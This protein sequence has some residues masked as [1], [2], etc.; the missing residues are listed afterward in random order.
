MKHHP[1]TLT[2]L[3]DD[4]VATIT[5]RGLT[6]PPRLPGLPGCWSAIGVSLLAFLVQ[7]PAHGA[8][9]E[10]WVRRHA[11]PANSKYWYSAQ[12]VVWGHHADVVV[13]GSTRDPSNVSESYLAN[14]AAEDGAQRWEKR[15]PLPS[16]VTDFGFSAVVDGK[17][18][19]V[20]TQLAATN[21]NLYNVLA[22][23]AGLDGAPLW[24]RRVSI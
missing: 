15:F 16:T 17:G 8:V 14:Y 10:A 13:I 23:Y 12:A 20:T 6:K 5:R 2:T 18:D 21:R 7:V 9:Q 3:W 4:G 24:E 19:V 1:E 22:K 11:G